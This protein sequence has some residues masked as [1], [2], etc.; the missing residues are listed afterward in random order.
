MFQGDELFKKKKK[1][2]QRERG[3]EKDKTNF[4]EAKHIK[5]ELGLL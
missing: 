1:K 4:D 3:K 2:I 5:L